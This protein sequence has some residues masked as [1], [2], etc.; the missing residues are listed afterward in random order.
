MRGGKVSEADPDIASEPGR[1]VVLEGAAEVGSAGE[2][3]RPAVVG[4]RR[5]N[6]GPGGL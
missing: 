4:E 6:G 1:A 5:E 3:A 2:V